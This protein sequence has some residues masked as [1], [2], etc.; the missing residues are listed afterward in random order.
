MRNL[1]PSIFVSCEL[2][3][4]LLLLLVGV[5]DSS[6]CQR[7]RLAEHLEIADMIGKNE[8]QR[9]V[10]IGALLV[11]QSAMRLDNGAKRIVRL[12]KIRAGGQCHYARPQLIPV[13][14]ANADSSADRVGCR[15]RAAM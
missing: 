1:W 5:G 15:K 10:E 12:V 14:R 11:A 4:L 2:L 8:N 13:A 6:F 9:R 7:E 3:L